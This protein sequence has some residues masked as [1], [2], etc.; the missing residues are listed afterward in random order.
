M[1]YRRQVTSE[2]LKHQGSAQAQ[3]TRLGLT[4]IGTLQMPHCFRR[5][6]YDQSV[7]LTSCTNEMYK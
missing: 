6:V 1:E 7:M 2:A 4:A 3:Y 5:W